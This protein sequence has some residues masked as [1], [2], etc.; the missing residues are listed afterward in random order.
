V[1]HPLIIAIDGPSGS[2]KS[3]LGRLLARALKLLYIDTGS[4]YRAA[5][6]AVIESQ[7]DP[8]DPKAVTSLAERLNIDLAGTPDSLHVLLEGRDITEQIRSEAVTDVSSIVSAIPGVRRAMV[9]RQREIGRRGA[10]LNGRDIGTIVFPEADVKF[11]LTAAPEERAKRRF[12]E[13]RQQNPKVDFAETLA[14]MTERD[15]R[16]STRADS[17]LKIA[18]DAIVIDS[19][20]LSIQE[21][22]ERMMNDIPE[23]VKGHRDR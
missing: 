14:D 5:A 12:A 11:F 8:G 22:F 20:G 18:D 9:A 10:V 19:T 23:R 16:D 6:L 21:V 1:P 17:P 2:G 7:L 13:E 4:M 15:H 3:T